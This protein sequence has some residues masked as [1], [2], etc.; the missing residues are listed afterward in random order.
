[1]SYITTRKNFLKGMSS[2]S[3]SREEALPQWLY[4]VEDLLKK[5]VFGKY[6]EVGFIRPGV[7]V[8]Y[9]CMTSY[10]KL[11]GLKSRFI[12]ISQDSEGRLGSAG[13][14]LLSPK[15]SCRQKAAGLESSECSPTLD[16][17]HGFLMLTLPRLGGPRSL[18]AG[19]ALC[20]LCE[21]PPCD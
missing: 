20:I 9:C 2:C 13:W 5:T 14:F 12:I 6:S 8:I 21:A 10:L 19:Q 16:I 11:S 18:G 3:D 7:L 15:C 17:Q 1:M 4:N